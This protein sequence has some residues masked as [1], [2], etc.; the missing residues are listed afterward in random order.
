MKEPYVDRLHKELGVEERAVVSV[1]DE[2]EKDEGCPWF[3]NG[4]GLEAVVR[5]H[6]TAVP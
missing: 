1:P 6:A 5:Q 4:G 2:E 3:V